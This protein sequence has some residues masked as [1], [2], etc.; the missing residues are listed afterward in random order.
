GS[1]Q[2]FVWTAVGTIGLGD[3]ANRGWYVHSEA[4]AVSPD[5]RIVVGKADA[6]D[7]SVHGFRWTQESGL[8]SIGR[9]FQPRGVTNDGVIVGNWS[10]AHVLGSSLGSGDLKALL[11]GCG[12]DMSGWSLTAIDMT[13]DGRTIVGEGYD[14]ATGRYQA[15]LARLP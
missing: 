15:I 12:L 7:G 14:S 11:Q 13:S 2:A 5:G 4:T 6:A 3:F 1:T 8:V 9:N 10:Q